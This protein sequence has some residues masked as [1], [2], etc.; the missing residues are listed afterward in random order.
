MPYQLEWP[1]T[2]V[3]LKVHISMCTCF[4]DYFLIFYSQLLEWLCNKFVLWHKY[5]QILLVSNNSKTSLIHY[6]TI[7]FIL[8]FIFLVKNL[9]YKI[10]QSSR[11]HLFVHSLKYINCKL[12]E[13]CDTYTSPL[14]QTH[15]NKSKLSDTTFASP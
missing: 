10:N 5:F 12:N 2:R 7:I 13:K 6:M 14:D 3:S 15:E 1:S 4:G 9:G 11:T 8:C